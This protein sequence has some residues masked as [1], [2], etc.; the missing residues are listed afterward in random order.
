MGDPGM[1]GRELDARERVAVTR[2]R[3]RLQGRLLEAASSVYNINA[4]ADQTGGWGLQSV[5]CP[6]HGRRDTD[7]TVC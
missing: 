5:E 4:L 2:R 3:L 1:L 7:V 6:T